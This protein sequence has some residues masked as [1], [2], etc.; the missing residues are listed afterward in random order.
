MA[1][2]FSSLRNVLVLLKKYNSVLWILSSEPARTKLE[3]TS[4]FCLINQNQVLNRKVKTTLICWFDKN[5]FGDVC[6]FS[7]LS[8]HSPYFLQLCF[9]IG[10]IQVSANQG[11]DSSLVGKAIFKGM[12]S[13]QD[14][15]ALWSN[16]SVLD[17]EDG[18]SNLGLG[19]FFWCAKRSG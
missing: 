5:K 8:A 19:L 6:S 2:V 13:E 7:F 16:A 17:R 11:S 18:G 14:T 1:M 15:M 9:N 4:H 10:G 3:L 12:I